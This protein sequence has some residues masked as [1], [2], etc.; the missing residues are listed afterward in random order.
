M[1]AQDA[2][3]R[4]GEREPSGEAPIS[5]RLRTFHGWVALGFCAAVA[6]YL[7]ALI[8]GPPGHF[9]TYAPVLPLVLLLASGAA[10][11]LRHYLP[12]IA[13]RTRRQTGKPRQ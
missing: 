8:G 10:M 4:R 2:K 1:H 13:S 3:A 5:A 11:L 12:A 6:A 7:L 9:V